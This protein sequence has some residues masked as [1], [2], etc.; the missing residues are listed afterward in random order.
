MS[1]RLQNLFGASNTL[2]R[3]QAGIDMHFYLRYNQM[4]EDAVGFQR[5]HEVYDDVT[6]S[7]E[8]G[9][10]I[11]GNVCLLTWKYRTTIYAA[12]RSFQPVYCFIRTSYVVRSCFGIAVALVHSVRARE[13]KARDLWIARA[14][15]NTSSF[16]SRHHRGI[17]R[18]LDSKS[19]RPHWMAVGSIIY[20]GKRVYFWRLICGRL[21]GQ[22]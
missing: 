20:V 15:A 22:K 16:R 2:Y 14:M 13:P 1:Y 17:E 8:F 11:E 5:E 21:C 9:S 6:G 4:H 18:Y 10:S 7:T 3:I 12:C 19:S